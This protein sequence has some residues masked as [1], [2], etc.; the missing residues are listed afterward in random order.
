MPYERIYESS[1]N[2]RFLSP[3]VDPALNTELL[4]IGQNFVKSVILGFFDYKTYH[5]N[6]IKSFY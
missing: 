3:F 6:D 4:K 5:V 2:A 1:S